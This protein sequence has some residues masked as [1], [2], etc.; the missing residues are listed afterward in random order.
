MKVY[1]YN[2]KVLVNSANDK[3][4]KAADGPAYETVIIGSQEWMVL[5]TEIDDGGTGITILNTYSTN[6][7]G[8]F[9]TFDA[10]QRI[11][12]S[13]QGFHIPTESEWNTLITVNGQAYITAPT[14][15]KTNGD[16]CIWWDG[17][18]TNTTGFS[19]IPKGLAYNGSVQSAGWSFNIWLAN[20]KY[21]YIFKEEDEPWVA[22]TI[23]AYTNQSYTLRLIKDSN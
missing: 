11:A 1:T 5:N 23:P 15:A 20:G 17:N 21:G 8:Y 4:L 13:I 2:D 18:G 14:L 6:G 10:A 12:N 3:W 16:D 9:Y 22:T 19:A 7:T